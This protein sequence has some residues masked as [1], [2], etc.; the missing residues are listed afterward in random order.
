MVTNCAPLDADLLLFCHER[1]FM[2][3]HYVTMIKLMLLK[4]LTLLQYIKMA[5][6]I[7]EGCPSKSWTFVIKRDYLSGILIC[8]YTSTTH[9]LQIWVK[10]HFR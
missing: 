3:S 8:Q 1:G 5:C 2:L 9:F 10:S 6:L 4:N 7:Y